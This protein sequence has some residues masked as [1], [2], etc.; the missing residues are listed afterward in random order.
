MALAF[1]KRH[2]RGG[3]LQQLIEYISSHICIGLQ[4]NIYNYVFEHF[5]YAYYKFIIT[6]FNDKYYLS[7]HLNF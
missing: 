3:S 2:I 6:Y 1:R 4:F 7:L 5:I